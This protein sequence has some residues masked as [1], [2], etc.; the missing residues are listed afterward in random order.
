MVTK[1]YCDLC[2]KELG[3]YGDISQ[4]KLIPN[5]LKPAVQEEICEDCF[6][7]IKKYIN[8]IKIK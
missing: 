5:K 6:N 2:K 4:L 8:E 3:G 7:K 1:I